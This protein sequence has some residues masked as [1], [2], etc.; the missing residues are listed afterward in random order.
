MRAQ[1]GHLAPARSERERRT[2][3]VDRRST[4][5]TL[6]RLPDRRDVGVVRRNRS[7]QAPTRRARCPTT[8]GGSGRGCGGRVELS[9]TELLN[10]GHA[11][12][13]VDAAFRLGG[14]VVHQRPEG[15]SVSD[16]Y[17]KGRDRPCG[18]GSAKPNRARPEGRRP[19]LTAS[20]SVWRP[21]REPNPEG[22]RRSGT[23][24][25]RLAADRERSP[26]SSRRRNTTPPSR[27]E[28]REWISAQ[29]GMHDEH[30]VMGC[31]I[32]SDIPLT[33]TRA[34]RNVPC[35]V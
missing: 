21:R 22:H 5:D 24:D 31:S 15:A 19:K 30:C 11:W 8:G 7:R 32:Q 29:A 25:P 2:P 18:L 27:K 33:P 10:G 16:R 23:P 20:G 6:G 14:K 26:L 9:F 3:W 28:L 1:A 12:R 4:H 13:V 34:S 35:E 17:P